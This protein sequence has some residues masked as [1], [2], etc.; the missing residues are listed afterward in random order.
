M[1]AA[2]GV[3]EAIG[4]TPLVALQGAN[5]AAALR[6]A[7]RLGRGATVATIAVD[8]GLRCLSTDVYR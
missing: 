5:G 6:V 2:A 4:N 7:A 8:S 3:L 1:A